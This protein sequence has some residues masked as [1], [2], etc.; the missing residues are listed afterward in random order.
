MDTQELWQLHLIS[1]LLRSFQLTPHSFF[2]F[3]LF[4]SYSLSTASLSLYYQLQ[5]ATAL[6]TPRHRQ[7]PT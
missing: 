5:I 7:T 1:L 4:D 6:W 2:F 3:F